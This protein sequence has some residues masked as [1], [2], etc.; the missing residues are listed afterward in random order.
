VLT[1]I[2]KCGGGLLR[3]PV[4]VLLS[5]GAL[6][7]SGCSADEEIGGTSEE[8]TMT[9]WVPVVWSY[10]ALGDS[11]VAGTGVSCEGYVDRYAAY[12]ESDTSVR[13]NVNNLGQNGL[14]S[15]ELLFALRSDPS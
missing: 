1:A 9:T 3:V 8:T 4:V 2:R 13:V 6:L 7:A 11:L 15:P 12:F 14:T 10:V 5:L